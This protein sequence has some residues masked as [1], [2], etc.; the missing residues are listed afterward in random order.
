MKK[1]IISVDSKQTAKVIAITTALFSL[2]FTLVGL[3]MIIFG[4]V[5]DSDVTKSM[6]LIYLLMPL[7]YII[8]V[9]VFSRLLYWVYNKVAAR[10]GG[11]V[12]ELED[13]MN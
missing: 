11:V 6:G 12:F 1:E 10:F 8:L 7:W 2:I 9:Y 13:K 5:M 4:I 3:A